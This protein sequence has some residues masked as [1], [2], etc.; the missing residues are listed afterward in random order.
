MEPWDVVGSE[1]STKRNRDDGEENYQPVKR[2]RMET[3][4][5]QAKEDK[6]WNRLVAVVDGVIKDL[7]GVNISFESRTRCKLRLYGE[8]YGVVELELKEGT[9]FI[10]GVEVEED[11]I[12]AKL[13]GNFRTEVIA[14]KQLQWMED[15]LKELR[16]L[17]RECQL[18]FKPEMKIKERYGGKYE[19]EFEVE[20]GD[21]RFVVV[22]RHKQDFLRGSF[23]F[24][25]GASREEVLDGFAE[26]VRNNCCSE[27]IDAD[28]EMLELFS[29]RP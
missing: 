9:I 28:E 20:I 3:A 13:Y 12:T 25:G 29:K 8:E 5:M 2:S 17:V 16:S 18:L 27:L 22:Y 26:Y 7:V 10:D 24:L 23:G 14:R 19:G 11:M 15:E 6:H 21:Y 1:T 4:V